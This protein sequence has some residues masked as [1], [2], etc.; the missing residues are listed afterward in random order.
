MPTVLAG[1]PTP[2]TFP[3]TFTCRRVFIPNNPKF[4]ALIGGKLFEATKEYFWIEA[5]S[6]SPSTAAEYM[7]LALG[8]YDAE[9]DCALSCDE[10]ID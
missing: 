3:L 2:D 4:I 6:M 10:I 1:Y 9:R 8:L 5:G 7:A